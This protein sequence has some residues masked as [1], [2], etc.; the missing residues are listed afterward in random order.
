MGSATLT[1]SLA[2]LNVGMCKLT[3]SDGE[4]RGGLF[5]AIDD[6]SRRSIT[7]SGMFVRGAAAPDGGTAAL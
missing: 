4:R 1:T 3:A 6:V 7:E 2:V 5:A